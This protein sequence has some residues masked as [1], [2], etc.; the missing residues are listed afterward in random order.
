MVHY[1][2]HHTI[3]ISYCGPCCSL[4]ASGLDNVQSQ[5]SLLGTDHSL[6][7]N[8]PCLVLCLN[9]KL[10]IVFGGFFVETPQKNMNEHVKRKNGFNYK[11]IQYEKAFPYKDEQITNIQSAYFSQRTNTN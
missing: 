1:A 4:P 8:L 3:C 10:V 2:H 5:Q 6:T 9:G 11:Y 7:C